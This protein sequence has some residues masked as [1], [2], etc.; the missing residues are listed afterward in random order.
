KYEMAFNRNYASGK[1]KHYLL[2]IFVYYDHPKL[3]KK[4]ISKNG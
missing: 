1:L 4:S 2:K 3:A